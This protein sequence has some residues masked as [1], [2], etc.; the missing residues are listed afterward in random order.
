MSLEIYASISFQRRE[1]PPTVAHIS[2]RRTLPRWRLGRVSCPVMGWRAPDGASPISSKKHPVGS[3]LHPRALSILPR[4]LV[5][6]LAGFATEPITGQV[7]RPGR[8]L[9]SVD[10]GYLQETFAG[11]TCLWKDMLAYLSIEHRQRE[12]RIS[13]FPGWHFRGGG[14]AVLVAL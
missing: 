14:W 4:L 7:T 12:N 2:R 5:T 11:N 9:G 8:H 6:P 10:W 1:L 3:V 13:A